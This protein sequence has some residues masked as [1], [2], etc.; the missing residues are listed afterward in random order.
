MTVPA[1]DPHAPDLRAPDPR[2]YDPRLPVRPRWAWL[3]FLWSLIM[4]GFGHLHIGHPL[5]G[6][7]WWVGITLLVALAVTEGEGFP[8]LAAILPPPA[9]PVLVLLETWRP[10]WLP[11]ASWLPVAPGF[12]GFTFAFLLQ[13]AGAADAARLLRAEERAGTARPRPRWWAYLLYP[14]LIFALVFGTWLVPP[15]DANFE[16]YSISSGSGL[17][18]LV[19]GD[20]IAVDARMNQPP[21]LRRGEIVAYTRESDLDTFVHRVVGLPG[22]RIAFTADG[23]LLLNGGPVTAVPAGEGSDSLGD[24]LPRFEETLPNMVGPAARYFILRDPARAQAWPESVVP[25]GHVFVLGD[26]RDASADSRMAG[27]VPL[28]RIIGKARFIFWPGT[29]LRGGA[30]DWSR[31]GRSLAPD[32]VPAGDAVGAD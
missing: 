25:Q 14:G 2:P 5:R 26:N 8:A 30:R 16:S 21:P 12:A 6:L 32:W 11:A 23:H 7:V 4:P 1:P 19:I 10:F 22:D 29:G 13:I 15:L 28:A 18:N 3:A 24:P 9:G 20:L 31:L 27:P 17:P